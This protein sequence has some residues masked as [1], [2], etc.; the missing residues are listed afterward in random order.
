MYKGISPEE[1]IKRQRTKK[2]NSKFDKDFFTEYDFSESMLQAIEQ[3]TANYLKLTRRIQKIAEE[4]I[5]LRNKLLNTLKSVHDEIESKDWPLK[6]VKKD[7]AN[8]GEL[9]ERLKQS[10]FLSAHKAW[11][12][13]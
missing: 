4:L 1:F 8:M 3:G 12:S 5:P 9:I 6:F 10:E 7:L 13:H 11:E 2:R